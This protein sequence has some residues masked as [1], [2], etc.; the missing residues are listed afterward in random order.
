VA[1]RVA[2]SIIVFKVALKNRMSIWRRIAVRSDQTLDEFH[3][4]IF[5]AF[6]R[7]DEHLYSFYFPPPGV[8]GRDIV[9]KS[10]EFTSPFM[11]ENNDF[12]T[13]AKDAAKTRFSVLPLK[14]SQRFLYLFD[15]GDC[16]WHEITV[17]SIDSPC[18]KGK[19][20]RVLEKRGESPEQY[21]AWEDDDEPEE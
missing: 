15:F 6:D 18:D 19:Y 4:A 14:R 16:W 1:K 10:P 9:G 17:E 13:K 12:P 11:F 5:T 20:P 8:R 7:D 21:P 3:Q 2:P